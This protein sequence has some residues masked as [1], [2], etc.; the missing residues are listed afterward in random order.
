MKV[1]HWPRGFGRTT[2][3]CELA[4][5]NNAVVVTY[6]EAQAVRLQHKFGVEAVG[7]FSFLPR[8]KQNYYKDRV[9]YIDD[10]D[11]VLEQLL[12]MEID[13]IVT[14]QTDPLVE[15]VHLRRPDLSH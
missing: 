5:Q 13:T 15:L 14:C 4:K 10:A 11:H 3:L 8:V 1:I 7:L 12:G 9:I 2:K 6:N